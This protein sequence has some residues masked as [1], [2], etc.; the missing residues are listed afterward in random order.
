MRKTAALLTGA[1]LAL[2][3]PAASAVGDTGGVPHSGK[4]C[5]AK[6]KGK[7]PTKPAPNAKG[8]KCGFA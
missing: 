2:S 3:L 8:K 4:P 6:G 7:G 5:P 1:A